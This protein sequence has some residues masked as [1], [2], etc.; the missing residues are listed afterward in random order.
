MQ[1][2]VLAS[3]GPV[4]QIPRARAGDFSDHSKKAKN[5]TATSVWATC[6]IGQTP[7]ISRLNRVRDPTLGQHRQVHIASNKNGPCD[8]NFCT[9]SGFENKCFGEGI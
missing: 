6:K 9:T 1:F 7:A 5:K 2:P 3:A 8:V 4:A